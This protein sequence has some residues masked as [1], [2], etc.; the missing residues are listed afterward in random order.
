MVASQA[1][2]QHRQRI[3]ANCPNSPTTRTLVT[4]SLHHPAV[5]GRSVWR[6]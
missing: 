3:V 6:T 1:R 4:I 2:E 5:N